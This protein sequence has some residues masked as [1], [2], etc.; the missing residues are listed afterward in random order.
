MKLIGK[1]LSNS[2]EPCFNW[3]RCTYIRNHIPG[4]PRQGDT[5]V[6]KVLATAIET[7]MHM[8]KVIHGDGKTT[9]FWK[10]H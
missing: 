9:S 6:W 2:T 4:Q 5:A 7:T 1:L 8:T 3:L 10:D